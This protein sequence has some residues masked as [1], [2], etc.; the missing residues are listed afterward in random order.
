M[1]DEPNIPGKP[2]HN[3][4]PVNNPGNQPAGKPPAPTRLSLT[5]A[6][7]PPNPPATMEVHHPHHPAHKK[8]W[9]EYLLEFLM[10][11]LAVFLGFVA[12]NIREHYVE[13]H[14]E[15]T[16]MR[17]LLQ[18]LKFDTANYQKVMN[19]IRILNPALDS[20]YTNVKE[21]PRFNNILQGR[22]QRIVNSL[23]V[24]YRPGMP[25]IQ[26]MQS[27]GNLRL[28]EKNEVGKKIS[29]YQAFAKGSLERG[30]DNV[31]AAS[32]KVFNFEDTHCDYSNFRKN[33]LTESD[34]ADDSSTVTGFSMALMEKD[35]L[36]L[37]EFANS[38]IN[39]QSNNIGYNRNVRQAKK[40]ATELMVLINREY[41][42]EME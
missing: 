17:S 13:R 27:S 39:Y 26:L 1:S 4:P 40:L 33:P 18:E 24:E 6:T 8:K 20:S 10:L 19:N 11:F 35:P 41:G 3:T 34:Q 22:W 25:T 29:E 38:F 15:V 21:A 12:E 36:K 28:I 37:N 16:Y 32:L 7:P 14:R 42:L 23:N 9:N 5:K 30:N 2:G 31:N